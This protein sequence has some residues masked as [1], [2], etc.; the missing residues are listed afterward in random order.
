MIEQPAPT[1]ADEPAPAPAPLPKKRHC[2]VCGALVTVRP[3]YGSLMLDYHLSEKAFRTWCSG[4]DM[5]L[6]EAE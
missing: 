1:H 5:N 2:P 6:T 4:S 3:V